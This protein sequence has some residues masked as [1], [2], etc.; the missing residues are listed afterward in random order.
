MAADNAGRLLTSASGGDRGLNP[1]VVPVQDV[2]P[3]ENRYESATTA[4]NGALRSDH[5]ARVERSG[6]GRSPRGSRARD[7]TTG[8]VVGAVRR[9]DP[10]LDRFTVALLAL[11]LHELDQ[12]RN[13]G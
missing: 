5:K 6:D 12:E 9:R 4:R 11:A 13:G 3:S 7:A 8:V 2:E 10:D 1:R